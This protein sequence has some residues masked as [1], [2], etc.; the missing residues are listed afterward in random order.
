MVLI[1]SIVL[2]NCRLCHN[3]PGL[4]EI[5][6]DKKLIRD[7]YECV[8]VKVQLGFFISIFSTCKLKKI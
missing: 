8:K 1:E 7:I 4:Y 5:N 6:P 3:K 2:D